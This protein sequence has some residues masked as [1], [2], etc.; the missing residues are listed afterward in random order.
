MLGSTA[1]T[2]WTKALSN[3][4]RQ[5]IAKVGKD[6]RVLFFYDVDEAKKE[7]GG[8]EIEHPVSSKC[9][10]GAS[11]EQLKKSVAGEAEAETVGDGPGER[12]GR[13]GEEGGNAD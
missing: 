5:D 4:S 3:T 8:E 10:A 1:F 11:G 7:E 13:D 12:D 6:Q 9:V 2:G